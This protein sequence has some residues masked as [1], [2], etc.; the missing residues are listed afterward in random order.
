MKDGDKAKAKAAQTK[1]SGKKVSTKSPAK[2][3]G[4][5]GLGLAICRTIIEKHGGQIGVNSREGM[6]SAFW[7]CLPRN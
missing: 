5:K 3:K 4:G 7:F 1:A 2:E 6:G